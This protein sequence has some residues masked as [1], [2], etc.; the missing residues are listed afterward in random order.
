MSWTKLAAKKPDP[1]VPV[2]VT[3]EWKDGKS[4]RDVA[5]YCDDG[6]YKLAIDPVLGVLRKTHIDYK[7]VEWADLYIG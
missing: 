5:Y 6:F 1:G 3:G 7:V 4:N 2:I